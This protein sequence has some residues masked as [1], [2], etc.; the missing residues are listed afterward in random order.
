VEIKNYFKAV[1]YNGNL[2]RNV[3]S[4]KMFQLSIKI[5]QRQQQKKNLNK[6]HNLNL[7]SHK[8]EIKVKIICQFFYGS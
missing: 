2:I 3:K 7:K 8:K 5:L 4:G 1:D 6:K